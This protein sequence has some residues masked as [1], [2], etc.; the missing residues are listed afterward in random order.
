MLL[1]SKKANQQQ[2]LCIYLFM[3]NVIYAL[4]PLITGKYQ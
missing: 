4:F 3:C 2:A 1:Y